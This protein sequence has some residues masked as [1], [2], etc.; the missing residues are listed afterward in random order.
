MIIWCLESIRFDRWL[1]AAIFTGYS[2][3]ILECSKSA[4]TGIPQIV[5]T[6]ILDVMLSDKKE[7]TIVS[8]RSG[9][10]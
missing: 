6:R 5:I 8:S 7:I 9:G 4:L 2:T 10:N 3:M 1:I